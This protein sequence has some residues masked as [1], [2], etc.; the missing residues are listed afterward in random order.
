[1][2]EVVDEMMNEI[3]TTVPSLFNNNM[4]RLR[5]ELVDICKKTMAVSDEYIKKLFER[6]IEHNLTTK[7]SN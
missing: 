2:H 4:I 7:V 6:F 5:L 1:M 3:E